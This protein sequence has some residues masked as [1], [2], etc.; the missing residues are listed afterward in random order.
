VGVGGSAGDTF[1]SSVEKTGADWDATERLDGG[2][3][4]GDSG[5]GTRALALTGE[6]A[7]VGTV[8]ADGAQDGNVE[9]FDTETGNELQDLDP[10]RSGL[11]DGFGTSVDIHGD[12]LIVGENDNHN[13]WGDDDPDEK[14]HA[15]I[16]EKQSGTWTH[17]ATFSND[18]E[19]D[20]GHSV[21]INDDWAVV[22]APHENADTGLVYIYE[23]TS[24]GWEEVDTKWGGSS[25]NGFG[26]DVEITEDPTTAVDRILAGAPRADG[27]GTERGRAFVYRY[28][29]A[30]ETW[31]Q[32]T[33]LKPAGPSDLGENFPAPQDNAHFGS[34]VGFEGDV[35]VVGEH[36]R[37]HGGASDAG[38]VHIFE[39]STSIAQVEEFTA[40]DASAGDEYGKSATLDQETIVVG[41]PYDDYPVAGYTDL[42]TV[43]IYP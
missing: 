17:T 7:V 20:Y 36:L 43:Y 35:A 10:P 5:A 39:G 22:G 25:Q 15:L 9:I 29:G 13:V 8:A 28:D 26:A 24:S 6:T 23:N 1:G 42:G 31:K 32:K 3:D 37:D 33:E 38:M 41:A 4:N 16:Y 2:L 30:D 12:L 27:D 21:A 34:S 40:S 19:G 18:H 14:D 11:I